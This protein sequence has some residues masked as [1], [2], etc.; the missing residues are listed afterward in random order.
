[1]KKLN[2]ISKIWRAQKKTSGAYLILKRK[3]AGLKKNAT[4][5]FFCHH[6][7]ILNFSW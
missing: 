3:F 7:L 4:S 1:M 6:V 5:I 2:P